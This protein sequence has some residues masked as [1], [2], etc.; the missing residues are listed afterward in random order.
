[1]FYFMRI[2]LGA[3]SAFA[4]ARFYRTVVEEINPHVGRYLLVALA[5][6]AGM[7]Q[8]AVAYLPSSFSMIT[9]MMAFSFVLQPPTNF[10]RNRTYGATFF[11]G[12]GAL[13][14]WPFCAALG[15]PFV[16]EE[17]SV[18]GR[19][20]QVDEK[21]NVVK[22]VKPADWRIKRALRLGEAML[23]SFIVIAVSRDTPL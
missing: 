17:L 10:S 22:M 20:M 23:L 11:F 4:E 5:G 6:S 12:L 9:T 3:I 14:G 1:V 13:L 16:I 19:E 8:A 2:M 15:I 7:F 21:G 18:Y